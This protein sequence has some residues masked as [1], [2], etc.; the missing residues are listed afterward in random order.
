MLGKLIVHAPDR[1]SAIAQLKLALAG[2]CVLGLPTNR[3]LL[4]A[5]LADE[6]F[7]AGQAQIPFL[8]ERGDRLRQRLHDDEQRCLLHA[9]LAMLCAAHPAGSAL[10][11]PFARPLRWRHRGVLH[12]A[13]VQDL[14]SGR[15]RLRQGESKHQAVVRP[16]GAFA[17]DVQVDGARQPV[18]WHALGDARW[19]LQVGATELW[20]HDASFEPAPRAGQAAGAAELRAPFNGKVLAIAAVVGQS[21]KRGDTVLTL[22]SMKL[23]HALAA[24][25]DGTVQ[26][27]AVQPGQQVAS[28]Q[29]LLSFAP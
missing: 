16:A 19:H 17:L 21:I 2:S 29:L 7:A 26:S 18:R 20:L 28:A 4:G 9:A 25:R 6:V 13:F 22:E 11:P 14:G 24:P 5:C 23:E 1:A 12:E 10:P 15:W 27:I 8:A 3:A